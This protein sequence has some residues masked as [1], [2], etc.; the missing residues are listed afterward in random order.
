MLRV[1]SGC[2]KSGDLVSILM[3]EKILNKV[4]KLSKEIKESKANHHKITQIL[5]YVDVCLFVVPTV[6]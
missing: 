6:E 1:E 4:H 2:K 5:E 3:E